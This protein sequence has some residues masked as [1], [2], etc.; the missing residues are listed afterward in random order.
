VWQAGSRSWQQDRHQRRNT[1]WRLV[2]LTQNPVGLCRQWMHSWMVCDSRR[3]VVI[4]CRRESAVVAAGL[5]WLAATAARAACWMI[6]P[7]RTA[8]E[9]AV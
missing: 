3:G 7:V 8:V 4:A 1:V 6:R 9:R 5:S 2:R